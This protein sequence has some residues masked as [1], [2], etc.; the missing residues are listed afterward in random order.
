ME[1]NLLDLSDTVS[2]TINVHSG[3]RSQAQQNSLKG[4][5]ANTVASTSQHTIGDAADISAN[6]ISGVDLSKAAVDSGNFQRVN[7]YPSGSVHID[8]KNV[9]KGTQFYNNWK[10][11]PNP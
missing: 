10:R 9:G 4:N 1:D 5:N 7:L 3:V 2:S 8:Q 11:K 6:N